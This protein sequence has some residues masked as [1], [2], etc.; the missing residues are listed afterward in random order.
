V[1]ERAAQQQHQPELM[2]Q[3]QGQKQRQQHMHDQAYPAAQVPGAKR[4]SCTL[5]RAMF[6]FASMP[7]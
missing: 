6:D 2:N 7:E 1:A 4:L 3:L 5:L